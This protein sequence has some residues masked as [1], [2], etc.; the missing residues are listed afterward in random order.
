MNGIGRQRRIMFNAAPSPYV[1]VYMSGGDV[2]VLYYVSSCVICMNMS[3]YDV[4]ME[5]CAFMWYYRY[6]FWHS[7]GITL[8]VGNAGIIDVCVICDVVR[9]MLMTIIDVY[10]HAVVLIY[11][12]WY[13]VCSCLSL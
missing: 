6:S 9:G 3:L 4:Y 7:G 2:Y 8:Y 11:M 1:A 10:R 12:S 5:I 13:D